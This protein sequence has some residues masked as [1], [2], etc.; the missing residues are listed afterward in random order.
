[1]TSQFG[2]S[3]AQRSTHFDS[4]LP[5]FWMQSCTAGHFPVHPF[6]FHAERS[7]VR[8]ASATFAHPAVAHPSRVV[9]HF[10]LQP[11]HVVAHARRHASSVHGFLHASQAL[12][13]A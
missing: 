2:A 10:C 11:A 1:V 5:H 13:H 7:L 12:V 8:H 3:F 9:T 6:A 4:M